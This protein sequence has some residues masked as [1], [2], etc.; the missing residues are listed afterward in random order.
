[1]EDFGILIGLAVLGALIVLP[2]WMIARI[3]GLRRQLEDEQRGNTLHWQNL[4]A[5][6]H[7][8]ETEVK[9]LRGSS[10]ATAPAGQYREGRSDVPANTPVAEISQAHDATPTIPPVMADIVPATPP[11]V[12]PPTTVL[13]PPP[14]RRPPTPSAAE[15]SVA[16]PS[17]PSEVAQAPQPASRSG[18]DLEEM[19]GTNWLNKIGIGI[20]VL[21]LAFFLAYQLQNLGPAGK[22]LLGV[23]LSGGMIAIG[24]RYESNQRYRILARAS[25]AGG[26]SLLYFV[27]YAVY[28]VPAAHV[29]ESRELDFFLMIAVAAAI[30]WY[31]LRYKSQTTTALALVLSYLTVGI[32]HAS[33]Y[34][35]AASIILAITIVTLALRMQWFALEIFGILATYFNHFLWVSPVIE[36]MGPV[37]VEFPEFRLSILLLVF[38]WLLFR[39]SYIYR[40]I[41]NTEQE[42][43]STAAALL[44][45]FCLLGL[46]RYQSVHPEWAF[47]ALLLLGAVELGLAAL[48]ARRRR[49]AFIVLATL[50]SALLFAAI[51][52]HYSGLDLSVLWLIAAE[53]F[54]LAGV[55]TSEVVFRRVGMV[56]LLVVTGQMIFG[57]GATLLEL[58]LGNVPSTP[59]DYAT[60]V[61]FAVGSFL[62]YLNAHWVRTRWP[63]LFKLEF[64]AAIVESFTYVGGFLALLGTWF[65]FPGMATAVVWG[66]LALLLGVAGNKFVQQS[67]A[68]QGNLAALAAIGRLITLNLTS[69]QQWHGLSLRLVTVG[70]TALLL[71]AAAPFARSADQEDGGPW[72]MF[73]AAYTWAASILLGALIWYE[74]A[75][76]NVAVA[77]MVLG[78]V[79][80]EI[81]IAW[82]AG[83][84]RWQSYTALTAGFLQ[85]M[86]ANLEAMGGG[87]ISPNTSRVLPLALAYYYADWRLGRAGSKSAESKLAGKFFAYLG[88]ATLV[89]LLYFELPDSW[90]A[91]GWAVLALIAI[92]CAF[93]IQRRD[94][95]HHS[96]LVAFAVAIR[97]VGYNFFQSDPAGT[98]FAQSQK[99][100]AGTA[101]ALLFAGLPFAFALRRAKLWHTSTFPLDRRPE[102]VFFFVPVS[103]LTILIALEST[104]GQLTVNWG[105][106]GV[107]AFL[108]AVWVGERSFR[109]TGLGLLLAC[110]AKIFLIDVWGLDPQSKYI[111]LIALGAALVLVSYL[112]TRYK[113]KF[114][115][116]L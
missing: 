46:F 78:L 71:Y 81:G 23:A 62:C 16:A 106:E 113:E 4:T 116:Y 43:L 20:L 12:E 38:Y 99:F 65:A 74:V 5:R 13:P 86:W 68:I 25:A 41:D 67:L 88:T 97:V 59:P 29:I 56:T 7:V 108:F 96:Y 33:F 19:L 39:L 76:V 73:T 45:G 40:K 103:L 58:R 2:I 114:R 26:W 95:L 24:V 8:L 49:V 32:H 101:I 77:W 100:Y 22:V 79:L 55:F 31:S 11:E 109:L 104:R 112:Y 14:V 54:L 69:D 83:F 115:Q 15:T 94:Y 34:S 63:E 82:Q 93:A 66:T 90:I 28:H 37:R 89:A 61:L 75:P 1:M 91:A 51:P 6:L 102:Q 44:N 92:A 72:S 42:R 18:L 87:Q 84:L 30:V 70:I 57:T 105:I 35:L 9:E 47:W 21:G 53:A 10:T 36:S 52:F 80:L 107:T 64:D 98:L 111:T 85:V 3:L 110:A 17:P 60:G 48:A 50:A 27:S